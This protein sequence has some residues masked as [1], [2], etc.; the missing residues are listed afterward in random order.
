MNLAREQNEQNGRKTGAEKQGSFCGCFC[1]RELLEPQNSSCGRCSKNI[2]QYQTVATVNYIA[3]NRPQ[4]PQNAART[5]SRKSRKSVY[6]HFA[7]D[8]AAFLCGC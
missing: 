2:E 5:A 3:A 6:I 8:R 4:K 7:A 1:G